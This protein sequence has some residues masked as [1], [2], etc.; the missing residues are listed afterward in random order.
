M[1]ARRKLEAPVPVT[2]LTKPGGLYFPE[3]REHLEFI[4]SGCSLLDLT[5]LGGGWPLGRI[6]N[7]VG[8][9]S[10][11]KTLMA[12]EA[13]ANFA[14]K[15]PKGKIWYREAEAAFD[16][17]YAKRLGL[18]VDRVDFGSDGLDTSWDTIEDIFE[19]IDA[20]VDEGSKQPGLY[21]IDSL[22]ALTDREEIKRKIDK[23]SYGTAKAKFMSEMLRRMKRRIKTSRTHLMIISQVRQKIGFVVGEKHTRA[24]GD[25]LHFYASQELWLKHIARITESVRGE[26]HAIGI[27]VLA[28][29][30]KNKIA[31]P[32]GQCMYQIRFGYGIED[33][34]ASL[35]WLE[36]KKRLN[37]L[38]VKSV[39]KFLDDID[40][41]PADEFY[42]R[43]E[44]VKVAVMKA[45]RE[46]Q[47]ELAP[48]RSKYGA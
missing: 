10:T 7:I 28:R 27:K 24:G 29:C 31:E 23:G 15:Y 13:C 36:A 25:A 48:S 37:L 32:F 20:K 14:R 21:I 2:G 12:I 16:E 44:K 3:D 33:L 11:G 35:E 8:D 9:K 40:R 22:D 19:D 43:N 30:K 4:P 42:E 47:D 1:I 34:E 26:K 41:L 18:P 46:I 39:D 5:V 6:S 17:D 38:G 45:W